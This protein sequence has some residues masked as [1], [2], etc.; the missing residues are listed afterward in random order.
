MTTIDYET[1]AR[2]RLSLAR[3]ATP[4]YDQPVVCDHPESAA[5]FL[6]HILEDYDREVVDSL[7]L[8]TSHR[9]IGHTLAYTGTLRQAYAEPRGLLVPPLLANA[10]AT[11]MFH[12]HPSGNVQPSPDDRALTAR[13]AEAGE[14]LGVPVLDHIILGEP[15]QYYSFKEAGTWPDYRAYR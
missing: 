2:Y 11:I 13:I 9:A 8:N 3:E 6:H 1:I 4:L 5:R 7:F 15:P 12:N 10:A 14:I